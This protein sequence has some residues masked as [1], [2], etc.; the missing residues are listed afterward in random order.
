MYVYNKH[1]SICVHILIS[2][3]TD[4]LHPIILR[5]PIRDM[6]IWYAQVQIV[7]SLSLS[8]SLSLLFV[9]LGSSALNS[10]GLLLVIQPSFYWMNAYERVS[11]PVTITGVWWQV[12]EKT[13]KEATNQNDKYT[14]KEA[15]RQT[16]KFAEKKR[17]DN[18][19]ICFYFSFLSVY[20]QDYY[21]QE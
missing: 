12:K 2:T 3:N 18:K 17:A 10:L 14:D 15:D 16:K 11:I 20:L 19:Q 1:T 4:T 8:L 21:G 13:R 5:Y 6:I 9:Y 7:L